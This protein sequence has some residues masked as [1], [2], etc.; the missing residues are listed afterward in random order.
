MVSGKWTTSYAKFRRANGRKAIGAPPPQDCATPHTVRA[1]T[2]ILWEVSMATEL[3]GGL[4]RPFSRDLPPRDF[5]L[6]GSSKGREYKTNPHTLEELRIYT[7]SGISTISGEE[8]Q[9]VNNFFHSCTECI[10]SEGI[11]FQ[12]LCCTCDLLLDFPKVVITANLCLATFTK[13]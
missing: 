13:C 8:L 3:M 6:C 1:R 12:H 9:R 10:R 4:W 11:Y 5:Y 7:H 2:E